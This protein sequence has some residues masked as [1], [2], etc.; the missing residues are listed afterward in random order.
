MALGSVFDHDVGDLCVQ[1]NCSFM[2]TPRVCQ[3]V[4]SACVSESVFHVC[5]CGRSPRVYM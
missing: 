3:L 1:A 2:R 4:N 5:I